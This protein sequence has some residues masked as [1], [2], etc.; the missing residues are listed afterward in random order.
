MN[1]DGLVVPFVFFLP[2]YFNLHSHTEITGEWNAVEVLAKRALMDWCNIEQKDENNE[3][4]DGQDEAGNN[5][6]QLVLTVL[7]VEGYVWHKC[8]GKE[9]AIQESKQMSIV[10]D[11]WKEADKEQRQ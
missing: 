9:K 8:E 10:V 7:E 2:D 11:H 6:Y 1:K 4:N 5:P 3:Q